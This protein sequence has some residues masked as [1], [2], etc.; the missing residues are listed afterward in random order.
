V[1]VLRKIKTIML[2][3]LVVLVVVEPGLEQEKLLVVL[4]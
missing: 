3:H 4:V 2:V 1:G